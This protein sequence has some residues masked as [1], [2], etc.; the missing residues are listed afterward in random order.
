MLLIRFC[1]VVVLLLVCAVPCWGSEGFAWDVVHVFG[2]YALTDVQR[3]V[4]GVCWWKAATV[5]VAA[6]V[7]WELLD[8]L[9]AVGVIGGTRFELFD[10]RGFDKQDVVRDVAGALLAFR[11]KNWRGYG[12]LG[13]RLGFGHG[14]ARIGVAAAW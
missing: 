8:E 3:D 13:F 4:L 1:V 6:G 5:T 11:V 9:Y 10:K 2:C 12:S 14:C 7:G